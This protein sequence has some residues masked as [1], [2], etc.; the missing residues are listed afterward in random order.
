[1]EWSLADLRVTLELGSN[2]AIKEAVQRGVGVA[3]LSVYA[4][5]TEFESGRLLALPMKDVHC[6]REMYVMQDCRRV[7]SLPARLLITYLETHHVP[8]LAS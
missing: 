8:A 7:L 3:V 4:V 5:Q 2:E 1:M 6:D